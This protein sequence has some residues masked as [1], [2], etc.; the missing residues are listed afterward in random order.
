MKNRI[1]SISL[2]LVVLIV[3]NV[4]F[5][6]WTDADRGAVEW[7]SYGFVTG[8]YLWFLAALF[9]PRSGGNDTYA[10]TLPYVAGGYLAAASIAGVALMILTDSTAIAL[11]VHLVLLTIYMLR[12]GLHH[13]ANTATTA[14]VAAQKRDVDYVR[15]TAADIKM[16]TASVDDDAA[17]KALRHLYDTVRCSPV[18]AASTDERLQRITAEKM[19]SLESAVAERDW[20]RVVSV[21]R[22]LDAAFESRRS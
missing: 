7:L 20:V 18:H 19:A 6:L 8:G 12:F 17:A 13:A 16:L 10:L 14:A 2:S 3:F 21:A 11:S 5:F 4:L 9:S 1:I 15:N 22:Q